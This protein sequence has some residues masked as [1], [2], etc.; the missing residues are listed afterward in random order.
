M[1]G[2][3]AAALAETHFSLPA[4]HLL[5]NAAPRARRRSASRARRRS[6]ELTERRHDC[7]P[8]LWPAPDASRRHGTSSK[9]RTSAN[10]GSDPTFEA[11]QR[12]SPAR[13]ADI[14]PGAA[15]VNENRTKSYGLAFGSGSA[16][17]RCTPHIWRS[18]RAAVTLT[19]TLALQIT[20][21]S[22]A[23]PVQPISRTPPR[24]VARKSAPSTVTL[25]PFS[26]ELPPARSARARKT[27]DRVDR[28][29]SRRREAKH[30]GERRSPALAGRGRGYPRLRS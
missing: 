4:E 23:M 29:A 5:G 13:T 16:R 30:R 21:W 10:R 1:A 9:R 14:H 17:R 26:A 22:C 11:R 18:T 25:M 12:E 19:A 7:S 27:R 20:L 6:I 28:R 8:S 24:A 15:R 2:D 3:S